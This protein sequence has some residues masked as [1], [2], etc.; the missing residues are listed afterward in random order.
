MR[1]RTTEDVKRPNA[2]RDEEKGP[3]KTPPT[4]SDRVNLF[5]SFMVLTVTGL[6]AELQLSFMAHGDRACG[7]WVGPIC[8]LDRVILLVAVLISALLALGGLISAELQFVRIAQTVKPY[9]TVGP[10]ESEPESQ[11]LF[12]RFASAVNLKVMRNARQRESSQNTTP[13]A[14]IKAKRFILVDGVTFWMIAFL[15]LLGWYAIL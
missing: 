12:P 5:L 13:N 1:L 11:G 8:S 2:C 7:F 14:P 15:L 6:F 9:G 10:D 3:T 4:Y